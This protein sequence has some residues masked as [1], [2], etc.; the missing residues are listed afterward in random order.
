MEETMT[1]VRIQRKRIKGFKLTS[2][3]GLPIIYVGRGS[4]W[5]NR[6]FLEN[7]LV[8]YKALNGQIWLE[9]AGNIHTVLTVYEEWLLRQIRKGLLDL[10]EL[11][12]KNVSCW[13][14]LD[15]PCHGDPLLRHANER[16]N[17]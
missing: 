13:C 2:P 15:H 11:H 7:G 12:N 8:K 6:W 9:G 16:R 1:P 17:A 5:G 10:A 4:K 14:R 3:N